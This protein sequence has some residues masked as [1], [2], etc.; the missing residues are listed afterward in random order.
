MKQYLIGGALGLLL[1]WGMQRCGLACQGSVRACLACKRRSMLRC[2]LFAFG[3]GTVLCAFAMWLAV[4]DI[5]RLPAMALSGSLLAGALL[6]G[7]GLGLMGT[8]PGT[9]LASLGGGAWAESLCALAG[10][11]ALL[12]LARYASAARAWLDGLFAPLEGTLFQVTLHG[13]AL[14][15]GSFLAQGCVGGTVM[16][17]AL[18]L[19][20]DRLP[21][22]KALPLPAADEPV[23]LSPQEVKEETFVASLPGE[24]PMVVDTTEESS[25]A[26]A[27]EENASDASAEEKTAK[28]IAPS[29]AAAEE[30]KAEGDAEKVPNETETLAEIAPNRSPVQQESMPTESILPPEGRRSG[31]KTGE[32]DG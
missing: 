25:E 20:G 10:G 6:S 9:A 16:L 5:D 7:V 19:P 11:G 2:L 15:P 31:A 26:D 18:L 27:Q 21:V 13:R 3:A 12:F 22:A 28:E 17:I 1:G 29:A 4:I 14:F 8:S 23:S 30:R 32:N 24:E